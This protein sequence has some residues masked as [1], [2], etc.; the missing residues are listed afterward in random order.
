MKRLRISIAALMAAVAIVAIDVAVWRSVDLNKANG[1][2]VFMYCA[3][4]LPM[5]SL[6][7]LV[8]LV[9]TPNLVR[10]RGLMP[11]VFGFEA[12]GWAI[13]FAFI[14]WYSLA[15]ET[16]LGYASAIAASIRPFIS[17]S[18]EQAP[19]WFR[20]FAELA[21]GALLFSLPQLAVALIGG[22]LASKFGITARFGRQGTRL[23]VP[24]AD[25]MRPTVGRDSPTA[26]TRPVAGTFR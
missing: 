22:L 4:V 1:E 12:A 23:A 15:T 16:V 3:G 13:V 17:P 21:F 7:I 8:G 24:A 9:S 6:L 11:F 20:F 14:S 10:G 5:A 19:E 25:G 26:E 18:V 2:S